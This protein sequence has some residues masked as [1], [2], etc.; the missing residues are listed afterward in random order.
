MSKYRDEVREVMKEGHWTFW[1][2]LPL[3]LVVVTVVLII[4]FVF[5][6]AGL[7]GSTAVEREV[8]EQSYQRSAAL[9]AQIATDEAVLAE[10]SRQLSTQ[11]LDQETRNNLEAQAAAV[12]VRIHTARAKQ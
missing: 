3:F 6:G 12:R 10:I 9:K 1:K 5:R 7:I 2:V 4:G 11:D 8:F